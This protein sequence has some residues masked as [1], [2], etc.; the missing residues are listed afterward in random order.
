[1][2]NS[3]FAATKRRIFNVF[4][5]VWQNMETRDNSEHSYHIHVQI[6]IEQ[7]KHRLDAKTPSAT[8]KEYD[9]D[10]TACIVVGL[11]LSV[12]RLYYSLVYTMT[13]QG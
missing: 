9:N 4:Q 1:M 3:K 8:L 5:N 10:K 6:R 2:G 7:K 13:M 11:T 12:N